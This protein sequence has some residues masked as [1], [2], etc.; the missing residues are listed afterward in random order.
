MLNLM[1]N[2]GV[3]IGC[4]LLL[5][6]GL[7]GCFGKPATSMNASRR[8]E[9][10][11]GTET[12][13]SSPE[14]RGS[15]KLADLVKEKS[16]GMMAITVYENAKLGTMKD[17]GEGMRMGTVDMG[18]FSVGFLASYV[19]V[20]GLFDLPY[21]YKDKAHELRVF[22]SEI[23]QDIDKK[24]QEQGLRVVCFFDA[25]TRQMTNNRHPIRTPDDLRGLRIRVP[26]AE[27]SI[28]GL[29][30]LGAIPT[31][32]AFGEVYTAL[33]QNVV[34]GQENP[35]ALI[36]HNRFYEV[37]K[38]LS[39]TNHQMF[40]QVLTISEKTWRKLS[41]EHQLI[42]MH[43]A[44]EAQAYQRDLAASEE[45]KWIA[46]LKD[47]GIQVNEVEK[48]QAFVERAAPLRTIYIKKLGQQAKELFEKIDALRN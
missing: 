48:G 10:K 25:G 31:P 17:R 2:A 18:T 12:A 11:L 27:A 47:K 9:L 41:Q 46:I 40:I 43:S 15:Q 3:W 42:L 36:L 22:D 21:I 45:I 29:K 30:A 23:G 16:N 19:P 28:E 5:L 39:L 34:E 6:L 8:V 24:M 44:K 1:K 20:L 7:T 32:M 38:Y 26:Q 13:L 4:L 33:K 37:Q 14:T 35:I